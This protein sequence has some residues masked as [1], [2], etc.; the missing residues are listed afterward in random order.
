MRGGEGKGEERGR[1]VGIGGRRGGEER[2]RGGQK[3]VQGEGEKDT[4]REGEEK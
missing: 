2:R 4:C 3:G 1:E